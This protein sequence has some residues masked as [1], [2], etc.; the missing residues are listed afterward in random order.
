MVKHISFAVS[1]ELHD[2]ATSVKDSNDMSWPEF[3]EEA[4]EELEGPE[5][6]A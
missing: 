3:L 4:T 1:E 2:R 5:E 6:Q